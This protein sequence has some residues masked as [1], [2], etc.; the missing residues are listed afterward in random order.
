VVVVAF[1]SMATVG[2]RRRALT[3]SL[4]L[5]AAIGAV[6]TAGAAVLPDLAL[7]FVGG[8][9]FEEISDHLW[10]F[11]ILGTV[12][13]MLQLLVYSVLARQGQRSAYLVWAAF[14]AVVALGLTTSS[15]R[16]LLSVVIT[17]D[18]VLLAALL[19]VSLWVLRPSVGRVV[20]A[21]AEAD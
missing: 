13:S 9:Q 11:A 14:V 8:Q 3:A 18:S 4:G 21:P 12:L 15:L 20:P 19:A 1:P 10:I 16:G 6:V 7:V 17:V 2:E 5:V